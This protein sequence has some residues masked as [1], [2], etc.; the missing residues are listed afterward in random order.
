MDEAWEAMFDSVQYVKHLPA[1]TCFRRVTLVPVGYD[2]PLEKGISPTRPCDNDPHVDDFRQFFLQ[3]FKLPGSPLWGEMGVPGSPVPAPAENATSH[4]ADTC[5]SSN[6]PVFVLF[7]RREDYKAHPRHNGRIVHRIEN[8]EA[9]SQELKRMAADIQESDQRPVVIEDGLFAHM[10]MREQLRMV[11]RACVVVGAH[12]A[13]LS[14]ILFA[15]PGTKLLEVLPP[16]FRRPHFRAFSKWA[17]VEY[18]PMNTQSHRP[19]PPMIVDAVKAL[20]LQWIET[21]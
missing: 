7:V 12:G 20:V 3:K 5:R 4:A 16:D 8:E 6:S 14:H 1:G 13:G 19:H 11:R 17:G 2:S 10:S 9:V 15:R 21:P 18:H